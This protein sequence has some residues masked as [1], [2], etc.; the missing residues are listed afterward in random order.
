M[1]GTFIF[2]YLMAA[3]F[4]A[5]QETAT[6]EME[7]RRQSVVTLKQHLAMREER[8]AEVAA[9]IRERGE[10]TDKKIGRIVDMLTNT[11]DSQSSKRRISE[12]KGEAIAG[13]KRMLDV[14]KRERTAIVQKIRSDESAPSEALMKDMDTI[15]KL[16]EK[17]VGQIVGL[18]KSMPGGEDVSKY[19]QDG[20]YEY[21]GVAY[22]NSRVSEEWRQNRRDKVESEKERRE[23]QGALENAIADLE[24]RRDTLKSQLAGGKLNATEKELFEQELG[25]VSMLVDVRKSQLLAVAAPSGSSENPASKGEADDLKRLFQ[26]ARKDIAEDFGK[27]VRLYHAAAAE[28][29]KIHEVKDNLAAAW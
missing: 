17:R 29:E 9:E 24:G 7:E 12:I 16:A 19:E 3:G 15:D 20:S 10:A 25:H 5:A 22:E 26:D 2:L 8:L 27:T 21:N 6:I 13:L 1:K 4:A 11:K 18:V 23:A 28:R 14:Y